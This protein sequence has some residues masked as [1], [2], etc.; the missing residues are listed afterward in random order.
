M[1]PYFAIHSTP[2]VCLQETN[3]V[4]K[5]NFLCFSAPVFFFDLK[6]ERGTCQNGMQQRTATQG[7][8]ST[9]NYLS[10]HFLLVERYVLSSTYL[11]Y[12]HS[13]LGCKSKLSSKWLDY[14]VQKVSTCYATT[15]WLECSNLL[16]DTSIR[17]VQFSSVARHGRQFLVVFGGF[18][19]LR[20]SQL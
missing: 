2:L 13:R 19:L 15:R 8:R 20:I 14:V 18:L 5:E 7:K 10:K 17:A 6:E 3:I 12:I 9:Y 4:A 16:L 1:F 11:Y